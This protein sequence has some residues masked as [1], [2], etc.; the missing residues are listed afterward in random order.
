MYLPG[1]RFNAEKKAI[2]KYY[3]TTIWS[4]S[5]RCPSCLGRIEIQ[6]DPKNTDYIIAVGAR[7]KKDLADAAK[8][9]GGEII[10][11]MDASE[12]E[13]VHIVVLSSL[14]ESGGF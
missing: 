13:E 12:R 9:S 10:E 2:G 1:V 8:E 6:T 7:K 5:F 11:L 14:F 3:T 4:F